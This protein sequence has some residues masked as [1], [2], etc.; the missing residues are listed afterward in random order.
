MSNTIDTSISESH[1]NFDKIADPRVREAVE[2][3]SKTKNIS[4]EDAERTL[5]STPEIKAKY[6]IEVMFDKNRTSLGPNLLGLQLWESGK[7]LHGG[8]D[9]LMYW[10]MDTESNLGC[11]SPI[12][13]DFIKG[14]FAICPSCNQGIAMERAAH[15]RVLRVTTRVLSEELVKT[16]RSLNSN[17]DIYLKYAKTD[18][19]YMAMERA[20]GPEVARRLKGMHIYPLKN[21]LKDTASGAELSSRFFAF[22]TS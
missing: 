4:S 21:I 15:I 14:P 22:L 3:A 6:K 1:K 20:K 18:A 16:F 7:R 19:H 17:A 13:S 9:A 5:G 8:G 2:R 12:G 10:C 11:K